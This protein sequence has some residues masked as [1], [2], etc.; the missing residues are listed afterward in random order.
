VLEIGIFSLYLDIKRNKNHLEFF[1]FLFAL[2]QKET[3][4][5]SFIK[6]TLPTF[7]GFIFGILF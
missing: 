4:R 5:S 6:C 2:T 1:I 7:K 3:K